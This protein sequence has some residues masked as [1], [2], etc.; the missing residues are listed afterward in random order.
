M[1]ISIDRI[2]LCTTISLS[3]LFFVFSLYFAFGPHDYFKVAA[4][5][6]YTF[7]VFAPRYLYMHTT[8]HQWS[9]WRTIAFIEIVG[10]LFVSLNALGALKFYL[11]ARYFDM[12]LHLIIPLCTTLLI[13][14]LLGQYLQFI[15]KYSLLSVQ[16]FSASCTILLILLWE[17]FEW[18][19][20]MLFGTHMHGQA[21]EPYDTLYDIMAGVSAQPIALFIIYRYLHALHVW[22]QPP[23]R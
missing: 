11:S 6:F 8:M 20:D 12:V 23:K 9:S 16:F 10:G 21:G 18:Q 17:Y 19:S 7:A 13:A 4:G 15:G 1:R 5:L 14:M 2:S 22:L 3:A